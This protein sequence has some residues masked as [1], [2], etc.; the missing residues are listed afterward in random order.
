MNLIEQIDLLTERQYDKPLRALALA[1]T[2]ELMSVVKSKKYTPRI[3]KDVGEM[4]GWTIGNLWM[5]LGTEIPWQA[6]WTGETEWVELALKRT[7]L[8]FE[9]PPNNMRNAGAY[10]Q[11]KQ[12]KIAVMMPFMS[13][14][15]MV[16]IQD[17]PDHWEVNDYL[18]LFISDAQNKKKI[19]EKLYHEVIHMLDDYRTSGKVFSG[20]KSASYNQSSSDQSAYYNSPEE[21]NA[22]YQMGALKAV[23]AFS[24]HE[25]LVVVDTAEGVDSLEMFLPDKLTNK[26]V[27]DYFDRHFSDEWMKALT[28][29]NRKRML[30]RLYDSLMGAVQHEREKA[31]EFL[32]PEEYAK[33]PKRWDKYFRK[34]RVKFTPPRD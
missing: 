21:L 12:N 3:A 13:H 1:I 27:S 10:Y 8:S 29:E 30:K 20:S 25:G 31:A 33:E 7:L 2:D 5:L 9:R 24:K 16:K 14:E 17:A 26:Q 15:K 23:E 32:T 22:Y 4:V 18:Y 28:P 6:N 34:Y 11:S 19:H